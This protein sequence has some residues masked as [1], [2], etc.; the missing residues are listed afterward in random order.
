M[1]VSDSYLLKLLDEVCRM[2]AGNKCEYPE[3]EETGEK[4]SVH[5]WHS[6]KNLSVRYSADC[7][8]LLCSEHHT[9]GLISA[10]GTPLKFKK[11]IIENLV[12]SEEWADQVMYIAN[13]II[14]VP[15]DIY[16]EMAKEKLL[17]ELERLAA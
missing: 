15:K 16:R 14:T 6:K 1:P 9:D 7:S 4:L 11:A 3:C 17:A 13:Q 12:R 8:I 2:R 5:H 10:H